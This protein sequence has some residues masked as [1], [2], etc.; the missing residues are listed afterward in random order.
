MLLN[1]RIRQHIPCFC[2]DDVPLTKLLM[3]Q[4]FRLSSAK[5]SSV[6][7]LRLVAVDIHSQ[8]GDIDQVCSVIILLYV[9]HQIL[10]CFLMF[11]NQLQ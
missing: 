2:L 7:L 1:K 3:S 4:L 10:R 9:D 5:G 6:Q 8:L 11:V